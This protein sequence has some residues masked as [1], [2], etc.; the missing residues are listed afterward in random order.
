MNQRKKWTCFQMNNFPF[1]KEKDNNV[2]LSITVKPNSKIQDVFFDKDIATLVFYLKSPPD[3]GKANKELVKFLAKLLN[4]ASAN[5]Q[6]TSG[7]T[8]RDKTL[9]I[10]DIA[11][12]DLQNR[13]INIIANEK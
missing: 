2:I 10:Q 5:I 4:I 6:L 12:I 9:V 11:L 1:L 7:Q 13:L 8:S 3:K